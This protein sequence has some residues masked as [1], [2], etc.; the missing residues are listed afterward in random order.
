MLSRRRDGT[1]DPERGVSVWDRSVP[2]DS[3]SG[4]VPR[5]PRSPTHVESPW[6]ERKGHVEVF[7]RA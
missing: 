6:R 3:G 7:G 1:E 5:L 4:P 2:G